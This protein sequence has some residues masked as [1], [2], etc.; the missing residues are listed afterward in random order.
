MPTVSTFPATIRACAEKVLREIH[1]MDALM[2]MSARNQM[3]VDL[4]QSVQILRVVIAATAQKDLT[5][6]PG[7]QA[8]LIITNVRDHRADEMRIAPMKLAP[9][10]AIAQK[11]LLVTL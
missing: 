2:L 9:S 10:G 11:D 6:M 8:V 4:E 1:M 7:H 3:P 5:E